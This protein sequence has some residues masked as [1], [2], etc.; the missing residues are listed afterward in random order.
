MSSTRDPAAITLHEIP[1]VRPNPMSLAAPPSGPNRIVIHACSSRWFRTYSV[2]S[3]P[4][5]GTVGSA[6]P[7]QATTMPASRAT[8]AR[9]SVVRTRERRLTVTS[10]SLVDANSVGS[11]RGRRQVGGPGLRSYD[12]GADTA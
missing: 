1:T 8:T 7:E 6:S 11:G 5:A 9:P 4:P 12:E 2:R 10:T 3:A